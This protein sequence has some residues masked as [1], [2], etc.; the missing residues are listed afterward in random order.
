MTTPI[1]KSLLDT[2]MYK[3]TMSYVAWRRHRDVQVQFALTCRDRDARL[4]ELIDLDELRAQLEHVRRL[5]LTTTELDYLRGLGH[6]GDEGYCE[7]LSRLQLPPVT[8]CRNGSDLVVTTRGDWPTV[9]FWEIWVLAIVNQL[10]A[11]ANLRRQELTRA[12]ALRTGRQRLDDK[13]KRLTQHP[14]IRFTDFGTRRRFDRQWQQEVLETLQDRIPGQLAGTS[15]VHLAQQL[16]LPCIGTMAHEMDMA[17][18][19]IYGATDASLRGS[20]QRQ[21]EDWWAEFGPGLAIAL[22]DTY[23]TGFFF[24]DFKPAQARDWRGLR[25]DSGDPVEFGEMAIRFYQGLNIDPAT[26]LV[27]FSDGLDADTIIQLHRRFAGRLTVGFGWGTNLTFDNGLPTYSLVM[28]LVQAAGNDVAKLS[29]N[30]DKAIGTPAAIARTTRVFDYR[31]T[32]RQ[33]CAV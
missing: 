25:Q 19:G 26:K 24:A 14:D 1:I 30:L 9:T 4:A 8:V 27:V 15:N 17:Y 18:A 5:R 32:Y 3:F 10:A 6:F 11:T 16:G 20:H 29:D 23:G 12:D 28:K 13:I 7:F 22:T 21:L 31:N 2:D 33:A